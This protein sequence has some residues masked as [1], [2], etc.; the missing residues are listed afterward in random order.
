[1]KGD[2]LRQ[3]EGRNDKGVSVENDRGGRCE[4]KKNEKRRAWRMK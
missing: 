3:G 1:M 2:G 4:G